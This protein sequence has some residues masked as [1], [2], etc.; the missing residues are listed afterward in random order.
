[1]GVIGMLAW[2]TYGGGG[3]GGSWITDDS[4]IN[5]GDG[6]SGGSGYVRV[7]KIYNFSNAVVSD[8]LL[9]ADAN[10][11]YR[12]ICLL[13]KQVINSQNKSY[14]DNTTSYSKISSIKTNYFT[15]DNRF[16]YNTINIGTTS[17]PNKKLSLNGSYALLKSVGNLNSRLSFKASKL[18]AKNTS[19][20][21]YSALNFLYYNTGTVDL[22]VPLA[23]TCVGS[24]YSGKSTVYTIKDA[25][26]IVCVQ[27]AG[28]GGGG[29]DNTRGLYNWA[30]GGGGGAGG[31]AACYL[32]DLRGDTT[33]YLN[34]QAGAGGSAGEGKNYGTS[35]GTGGD[36][37]VKLST[38]ENISSDNDVLASI[39][40]GGGYGGGGGADDDGG[41]GG[42]N[43]HSITTTT[44]T[45]NYLTK[46]CEVKGG[47]G[48]RGSRS[49]DGGRDGGEC[50]STGDFKV[51]IS[52]GLVSSLDIEIDSTCGAIGTVNGHR[53][54]GGGGGA[55]WCG[56]GGY[57]EVY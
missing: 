22:R 17:N 54:S 52:D 31:G 34:V 14:S 23:I 38:V 6:T 30:S 44:D 42:S 35:G 10:N 1:M 43:D 12:N 32:L 26:V 40:C 49:N 9:I 20:S 50:S 27:G 55:S 47:A 8:K 33:Y 13:N 56:Y 2:P 48:G 15:A 41:N 51:S 24:V 4:Y 25:I 11:K 45:S 53:D 21:N 28:G 7:Y 39:V 29:A 36:S 16:L 19:D 37:F 57:G 5:G 46:L 3:A 18:Y